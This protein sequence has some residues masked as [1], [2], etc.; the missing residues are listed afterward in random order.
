MCVELGGDRLR[1]DR[2]C[3]GSCSASPNLRSFC[4]SSRPSGSDLAM[5]VCL[6]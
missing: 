1:R 6:P 3:V 5:S 4:S 2:L